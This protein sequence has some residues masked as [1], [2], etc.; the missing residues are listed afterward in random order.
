MNLNTQI[1]NRNDTSEF[2]Q[3]KKVI[4]KNKRDLFK[5]NGRNHP[6]ITCVKFFITKECKRKDVD[7]C[8]DCE[9]F[10]CKNCTQFGNLECDGDVI[11]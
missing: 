9:E 2:K 1:I 8:F 5:E 7:D 3:E 4:T 6:C 11:V 10:K